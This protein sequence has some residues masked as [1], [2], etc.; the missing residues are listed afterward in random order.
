MEVKNPYKMLDKWPKNQTSE[1]AG[2]LK[3]LIYVGHN[4]AKKYG[5]I[6]IYLRKI[7][8]PFQIEDTT[9]RSGFK[10]R[11]SNISSS[12]VLYPVCIVPGET[13]TIRITS[14]ITALILS[15][16]AM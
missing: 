7:N 15:V 3:A 8:L 10:G 9:E 16:N 11:C 14:C 13:L 6:S 1:A 5:L 4:A 12:L 2:I